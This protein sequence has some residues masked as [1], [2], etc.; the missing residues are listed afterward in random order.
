MNRKLYVIGSLILF[1][2]PLCCVHDVVAAPGEPY[3]DEWIKGRVSG[4]LA[5]NRSLDSSDITVESKGGNV[6]IRGSVP[7][8]V[9][10]E[11]VE[12]VAKASDGVTSVTNQLTID[13]NLKLRTRTSFSQKLH[14]AS[15]TAALKTRLLTNRNTHGMAISV[16]TQGNVVTLSGSVASE[17]ESKLSERIALGTAGVR[18]VKN[19]ITVQ[20]NAAD[21]ANARAKLGESKDIATAVTDSWIS[22]QARA[23]LT[24]SNDYPGSDVSVS[25]INGTVTLEGFAR[26][27]QQRSLIEKEV[28]DIV[29]VQ[30]VV[31]KLAI[32]VN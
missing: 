23:F 30:S 22:T 16:E 28:L 1:L 25:S 11:F 8:L 15:I 12:T 19:N 4:A 32:I 17:K 10:R 18:Q 21:I 13:E 26:D 3:S 27:A 14:D 29:G 24:F 2:V 9:E 20:T 5:Y 31:N 7:T 6:T